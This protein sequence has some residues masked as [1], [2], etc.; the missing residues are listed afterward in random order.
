MTNPSI[1]SRVTVPKTHIAAI[2][3]AG[4]D[5]AK[6]PLE[7]HLL[8][9][10]VTM[11]T[12]ATIMANRKE[13]TNIRMGPNQ[14]AGGVTSKDT[15]KRIVANA[16]K[17]TPCAKVSMDGPIG[18]NRKPRQLEKKMNSTKFKAQLV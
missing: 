16:S 17:Q 2:I 12:T 4:E 5:V 6:V 13:I 14:R 3:M 7:A 10:E 9:V 8:D 18:L 1:K 15:V 11:V